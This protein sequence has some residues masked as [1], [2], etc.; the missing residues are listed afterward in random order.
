MK[1]NYHIQTTDYADLTDYMSYG[2]QINDYPQSYHQDAE[3]VN[4]Q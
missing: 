2:Y 1:Y 3:S 4:A